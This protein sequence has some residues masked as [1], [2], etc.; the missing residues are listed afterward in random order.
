M[1]DPSHGLDEECAHKKARS[2]LNTSRPE[3][4]AKAIAPRTHISWRMNGKFR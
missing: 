1:Q 4:P 2:I 3:Y